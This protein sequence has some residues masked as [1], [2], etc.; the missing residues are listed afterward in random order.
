MSYRSTYWWKRLSFEKFPVWWPCWNLLSL[1]DT[2]LA[3][4]LPVGFAQSPTRISC[5]SRMLAA[6]EIYLLYCS[7]SWWLDVRSGSLCDVRSTHHHFLISFCEASKP[8]VFFLWLE[9]CHCILLLICEW[10]V[11]GKGPKFWL[12]RWEFPYSDI[13][14]YVWP[15]IMAPC[16]PA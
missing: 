4:S 14:L 7:L 3:M 8:S 16:V 5:F 11:A 6:F 1:C 15:L 2:G 12:E 9:L 10:R 13:S